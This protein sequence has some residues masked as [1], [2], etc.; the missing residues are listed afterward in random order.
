MAS[1]ASFWDLKAEKKN[2]EFLD[3]K[4][5]E[6][7]VVLVH[8]GA[9]SCGFTGQYAGLEELHQKYKDKGLV[10]LGFPCN[11]F[12]NQNKEDDEGTESFCKLNF[13]VTYPLMKKSDVNGA[14]A[15]EVFK[16]LKPKAKGLLGERINWNFTKFLIDRK[17]NVLHRYAPTTTPASIEKD[18]EK[19]LAESA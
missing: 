18:I 3:L 14:Q 9:T 5:H 12:G 8:N 17:G 13:G 10:V 19:A 7:K 4:Q 2:G 1:V 16:Y 11:Q 6:G 15:N